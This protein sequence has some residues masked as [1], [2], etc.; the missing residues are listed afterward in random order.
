MKNIKKILFTLLVFLSTF[1]YAEFQIDIYNE[2]ID[3]T[4]VYPGLVS[5]KK[6][7]DTPALR[8]YKDNKAVGYIIINTDFNETIGYSGKPIHV[9]VGIDNNSKIQGVQLLK[10]SEPIVLIGIPEKQLTDTFVRYD[11]FNVIKTWL[12][13]HFDDRKIDSV[14][15][16]TVTDRVIDDSVL[17]AV[18]KFSERINL[19]GFAD[20]VKN[21]TLT[22]L[23]TDIEPKAQSWQQLLE[24]GS[25]STSK[26]SVGD[27]SAQYLKLGYQKASEVAES[28]N[29]ADTFID[30]NVALVSIEEVG[31]NI[32]GKAEYKNLIDKI[33]PDQHAVLVMASGLYSFRGTG[34]VRGGLFDRFTIEQNTDI[35]RFRDMQYKRLSKSYAENSPKFDEIGL[36]TFPKD[37][38]FNPT[39]AWKFNLLINRAIN[40]D[41]KKFYNHIVR[42]QLPQHYYDTIENSPKENSLINNIWKDKKADTIV[43]LVALSLLTI[44]FFAQDRLTISHKATSIIRNLFLIF[45]LVWIGFL[46][47]AQLSVVN[48][49]TFIHVL[50]DKFSWDF[51]LLDPL[52]FILWSSVAAILILWGR[53]VYCG[54]LCPFGALQELLNKVAKYLKVPQVKLPWGLHERLWAIKYLLFLGLLGA[55]LYSLEWAEHL[56][57]IEPFKTSIILNFDRTWPFVVYALILLFLGLFVERF[58]CRYLCPLGAALAIPAKLRIFN[59]LKRYPETCG[60]PCQTCANECMVDA[61]HPE[62]NINDNECMQCMHCQ[63]LYKDKDKCPEKAKLVKREARHQEQRDKKLK[64]VEIE[65]L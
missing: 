28:D 24:A 33:S 25:I 8:V 56:S 5:T 22:K 26:I 9:A 60:T 23:K 51:F 6:M 41:D 21:K 10:H 19:L 54:W 2:K 47:N 64:K 32:L 63:V 27:V 36:F 50:M 31:S 52:V 13:S 18:L 1:G 14:S 59:W 38:N 49:L 34:F 58:Y 42:Y 37:A 12:K 44:I 53:G 40:V 48:V 29:L 39:Q 15:G 7:E 46:T 20:K 45:T 16:A 65:N 57:E 4:T 3:L 43:L 61:I 11:N 55:S 35:F 17:H 62:G 30:L